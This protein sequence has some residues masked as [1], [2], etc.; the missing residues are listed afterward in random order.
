MAWTVEEDRAFGRVLL[1]RWPSQVAAWGPDAIAAFIGEV[2]AD[3][4]GVEDGIRALRAHASD[5]APSAA[6]VSRLAELAIQGPVPSYAV[7]QQVI[8]SKVATTLDYRNPTIGFDELVVKVSEVHEAIGRFA[9]VLGPQGCREMPD[10]QHAHGARV[11]SVERELLRVGKEW[12]ADPRRGVAA[13]EA[14]LQVGAGDSRGALAAVRR[15]LDS[16]GDQDPR[17]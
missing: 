2:Q 15:E 13:R 6:S 9:V 10:P 8:A 5:F 3:G 16:G 17:P 7:A 1:G 14:A 4:I 11:G 12:E